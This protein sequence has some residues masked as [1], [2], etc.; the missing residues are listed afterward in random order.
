MNNSDFAYPQCELEFAEFE[1]E[2][3]I[4]DE[5]YLPALEAQQN[6]QNIIPAS[7]MMPNL[8]RMKSI[9]K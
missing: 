7:S 2:H 5:G 3:P 8:K 4:S 1:L 9:L 6:A